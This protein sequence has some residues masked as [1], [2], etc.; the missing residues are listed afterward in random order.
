[1]RGKPQSQSAVN[2]RAPAYGGHEQLLAALHLLGLWAVAVAAPLFDL[3][4]DNPNFLAF[5]RMDEVDI[6]L[7]SLVLAFV[8]PLALAGIEAR[9]GSSARGPPR[10]ASSCSWPP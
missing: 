7:F 4:G 1:M 9:C 10:R 3:M 2:G 5:R 6:V 8:P